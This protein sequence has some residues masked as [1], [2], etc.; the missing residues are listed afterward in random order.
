VSFKELKVMV[1]PVPVD[2]ADLLEIAIAVMNELVLLAYNL[3]PLA[4][5]S[6]AKYEPASG[7]LT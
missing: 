5:I 2:A 4:A 6:A 3:I 7:T 1:S